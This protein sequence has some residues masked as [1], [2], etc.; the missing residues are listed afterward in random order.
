MVLHSRSVGLIVLF[1]GVLLARPHAAAKL[2]VGIVPFDVATVNGATVSSGQAM[3][4]LLRIE[5]VKSAKLQP[6][7]LPVTHSNQEAA[8]A[9]ATANSDIVVVGTVLSADTSESDRSA[10]SGGL[11]GGALG[12]GG[13]IR[14]TTT[15][16]ELHIELVNPKTGEIVD[17]FEV[18]A[19]NSG[20]SVGADFSTALGGIDN[21]GSGFDQSTVGKALRE[22]AQKVAAEVA[23]RSDKLAK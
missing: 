16:V 3:A 7:L 21:E 22:A 12:A 13:R 6:T 19:K 18:E 8:T 20:T 9:G 15:T 1:A 5:M 11:F 2:A 17:T 14:R 23:K 4:K 10:N